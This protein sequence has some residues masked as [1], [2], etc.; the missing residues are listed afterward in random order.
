MKSE[1]SSGKATPS[2]LK[3]VTPSHLDI[4]YD[5]LQKRET[6]RDSARLESRLAS[7]FPPNVSK[8]QAKY[9][10]SLFPLLKL[11]NRVSM[12]SHYSVAVAELPENIHYNRYLDIAPYDRTRVVVNHEHGELSEASEG[13]NRNDYLNAS[14]VLEQF[15]HKWWIATQAP[16]PVTAHAFLSVFLKPISCPPKNLSTSPPRLSRL[17]T[18][19]QLTQN[20]ESG[21]RK[22]DAYFPSDVG[23]SLIVSPDGG[24]S[25][26]ALK[27]TLR[28]KRSIMEAHCVHSTIVITPVTRSRSPVRHRGHDHVKERD[29]NDYGEDGKEETITIQ[30]LLYTA[31][32]DHGVP[33]P[34]DRSSL[35]AFLRLVDST[36]RD[37]SHIDDKDPDCDPPIVVGCSAGVGRTGSFIALSSLLRWYGFL[38]P[39]AFPTLITTLPRCPLGALPRALKDDLVVQEIDSLREQRPWM[40]QRNEQISLIY[41]IIAA[42]FG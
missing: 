31:W 3:S 35:L 39:P 27:V 16:L 24:G 36:N 5:I 25:T 26:S 23:K 8:D 38:P 19:V 9:T 1:S 42:A 32:P 11:T 17:R 18:I 13:Q 41:E 37:A 28:R 22:A 6:K 10:R 4:V 7:K 30:H 34:K 20:Y 15:G 40:V 2:W 12:P 14:W 21:R 29:E 33:E